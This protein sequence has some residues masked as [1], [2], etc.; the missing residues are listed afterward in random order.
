MH[1]VANSLNETEIGGINQDGTHRRFQKMFNAKY[2]YQNHAPD[3]RARPNPTTG[4]VSFSAATLTEDMFEVKIAS[5]LVSGSRFVQ[6]IREKTN[7]T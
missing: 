6:F 3:R 2:L 4:G 7:I 1:S 5:V